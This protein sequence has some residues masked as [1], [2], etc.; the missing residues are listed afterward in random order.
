MSSLHI[1]R[2]IK[3]MQLV[4]LFFSLMIRDGQDFWAS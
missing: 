4:K 3:K 1:Q 2:F